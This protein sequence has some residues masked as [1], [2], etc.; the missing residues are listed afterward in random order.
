[1][2]IF[3]AQKNCSIAIG[4]VCYR[5]QYQ[6]LMRPFYAYKKLRN[7]CSVS[8]TKLAFWP[9]WAFHNRGVHPVENEFAK[10]YPGSIRNS[11]DRADEPESGYR[12]STP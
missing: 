9:L 6:S 11:L 10:H 12:L 2:Q 8:A 7:F 5:D 3:F 4:F 1:M